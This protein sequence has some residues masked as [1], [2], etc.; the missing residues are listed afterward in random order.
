[1]R[2]GDTS[3]RPHDSHDF[4][5]NYGDGWVSQNALLLFFQVLRC[6]VHDGEKITELVQR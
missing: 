5:Y 3:L 6:S 1:M 2:D 4:H